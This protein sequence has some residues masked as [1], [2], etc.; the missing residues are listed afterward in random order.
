MY[1]IARESIFNPKGIIKFHNKGGWFVTL[2]FFIL[3]LF[4][5]I[6][7]I[8]FYASYDNAII[9]EA[10]TGCSIEQGN[11]VCSATDYDP[12]QGYDLYGFQLYIL[13]QSQSVLDI[14]DM[15]NLSIVLHGDQFSF[16]LNGYETPSFNILS[17]NPDMTFDQSIREISNYL[18]A[19][20]FISVFM[21][22]SFSLLFIILLSSITFLRLK[23]YITYRKIL[24]MI[25]FA[26][27]PVALLLTIHSL[28]PFNDIIFLVLLFLAWRS[29]FVLQ[30]ELYVQTVFRVSREQNI[31]FEQKPDMEQ[32]EDIER[33]E[34]ESEDDDYED[35]DEDNDR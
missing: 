7:G 24:K 12:S 33:V 16:Y 25:I 8:I 1:E 22:Q 20:A 4:M 29:I 17:S 27:T 31:H 9:T 10:S 34:D 18:L 2:Y 21:G 32:G 35:D 30:R 11:Y 3:V 6:G 26:A 13:N 28:V 23:K 19:G 5:S 14:N 15:S